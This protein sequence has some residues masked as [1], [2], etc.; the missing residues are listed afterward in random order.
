MLC[1]YGAAR[2]ARKKR[3]PLEILRPPGLK[4]QPKAEQNVENK[5][6]NQSEIR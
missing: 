6:V 4:P 1:N 3:K 2:Q 5:T